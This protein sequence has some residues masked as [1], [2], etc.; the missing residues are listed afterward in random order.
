[1]PEVCDATI[2]AGRSMLM[3]VQRLQAEPLSEPARDNMV[4]AARRLL[5]TT[6]KVRFIRWNFGNKNE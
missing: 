6:M 2:A 5:E 3:A 1:M 4:T